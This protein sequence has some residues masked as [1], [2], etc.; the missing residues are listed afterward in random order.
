MEAAA[1]SGGAARSVNSR[2][3]AGRVLQA[4]RCKDAS[5]ESRAAAGAEDIKTL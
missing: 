5:E 4:R 3:S 1:A 2:V